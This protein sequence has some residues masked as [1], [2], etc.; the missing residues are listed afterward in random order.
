MPAVAGISPRAA[1]G[2]L[3]SAY[4]AVVGADSPPRPCKDEFSQGPR[5]HYRILPGA[6]S[7]RRECAGKDGVG[8]EGPSPFRNLF[9]CASLPSG[10]P[11]PA[12]GPRTGAGNDD[13]RLCFRTR[14]AACR[15]FIWVP[16]RR[17]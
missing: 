9:S 6:R 4:Q 13:T 17:R 8:C 16:A 10:L 7:P 11:F 14:A 15:T 2:S 3:T 5:K 12:A 1:A